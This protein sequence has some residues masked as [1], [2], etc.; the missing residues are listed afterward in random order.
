MD[1]RGNPL[2]CLD[3][4]RM[5]KLSFKTAKFLEKGKFQSYITCGEV[6]EWRYVAITQRIF[7]CCGAKVGDDSI[8]NCKYIWYRKLGI[9]QYYLT[10]ILGMV[11][12]WH[13]GSYCGSI[14]SLS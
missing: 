3:E 1:S 7:P 8:R 12:Y 14:F 10:S 13:N 2:R 11:H 6:I 5:Q 9:R 4:G